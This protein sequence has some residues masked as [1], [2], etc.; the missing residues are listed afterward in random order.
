MSKIEEYEVTK[1]W[2]ILNS[3]I[4]V[5][6]FLAFTIYFPFLLKKMNEE[7]SKAYDFFV[8][9]NIEAIG[10]RDVIY[11][12]SLQNENK[13]YIE[14]KD[15]KEIKIAKRSFLLAQPFY[16]DDELQLKNIFLFLTK[17]EFEKIKKK[18]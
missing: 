14:S 8:I 18:K 2:L 3:A 4:V 1:K 5:I 13:K 9:E 15:I 17:E 12:L 11:I 16:H 10:K 6:V 7:N